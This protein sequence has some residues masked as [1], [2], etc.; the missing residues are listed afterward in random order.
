[1]IRAMREQGLKGHVIQDAVVHHYCFNQ[2]EGPIYKRHPLETITEYIL[3][4][5]QVDC[6]ARKRPQ[7][8]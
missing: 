5:R 3:K 7:A 1:M 4:A 2:S 8:A 6:P